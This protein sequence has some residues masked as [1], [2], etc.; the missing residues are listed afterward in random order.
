[1]LTPLIIIVFYL[2]SLQYFIVKN[3]VLLINIKKVLVL[4]FM[5]ICIQWRNFKLFTRKRR[6]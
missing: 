4:C 5:F 3:K 1:M 2:N 6:V